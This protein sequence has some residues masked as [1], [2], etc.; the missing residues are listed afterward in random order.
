M[1]FVEITNL[2]KPGALPIHAKNCQSF[3]LKFRGLMFKPS[4][5]EHEGILID[6]VRENRMNTSI[7]MFFMRMEIVVVWIDSRYNVID[8]QLA[9]PWRPFY[10]P[11]APAR[12]VL[13]THPARLKDFTPGDV[14]QIKNV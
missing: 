1:A 6:E 7:H 11:S 9:R 3:W 2:S 14:V 5:G 13:E 10:M 12:Y 8:V 4:L